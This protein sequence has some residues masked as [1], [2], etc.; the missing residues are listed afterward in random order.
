MVQLITRR[1]VL[2]SM[3]I[4]YQGSWGFLHLSWSLDVQ[5]PPRYFNQ[6]AGDDVSRYIQSYC[7]QR[8]HL[9][10]AHLQFPTRSK[11]T[12]K[13]Q[14]QNPF[15]L[16]FNSESVTHHGIHKRE[17]SKIKEGPP[18]FTSHWFIHMVQ[19]IN[20]VIPQ[21]AICCRDRRIGTNNKGY[22]WTLGKILRS[23][24][25][26]W[27]LGAQTC[28][29]LANSCRGFRILQPHQLLFLSKECSHSSFSSNLW[30][31]S[32]NKWLGWEVGIV[33]VTSVS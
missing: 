30:Q 11:V 16:K 29:H 14:P 3:H 20:N 27:C 28:I 2:S 24:W 19:L 22:T 6:A 18:R 21:I 4:V 12:K 8:T 15:T 26:L 13:L 31:R 25:R 17:G 10:S 1:P 23:T 7:L 9:P 33:S 32:D 5:S